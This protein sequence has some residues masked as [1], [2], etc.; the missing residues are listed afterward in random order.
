MMPL[1]LRNLA[2]RPLRSV[3]AVGGIAV[4]SAML[5]DMVML[6][7]GIERSFERMLLG[8]GYQ[9]RLSPKGTLPFD[10]EASLSGVNR[11]LERLKQDP[12]I[13]AVAPVLGGSIYAHVGDSL[14][15]LFGYGI[16]PTAQPLYEVEAGRD[17]GA[18]DT[19]GILLS[20]ASA[21][22]IS[23]LPGDTIR[24]MG[25][26]DPQVGA[27][28]VERPLVV[29]GL[30][31]WL[32]DYQD[33][34]SVGVTLS[35]MQR[36]AGPAGADRASLVIVKVRNDSVA[37][38]VAGRL[39]AELPRIEVNSVA[40]LVAH[41][42]ERLV[43]FRQLSYILGTVSLIVTVL[44]VATLLTITV[45]ERLGEIATLRAIGVSRGRIVHQMLAEGLTLTGIGAVLGVAL[46]LA[47][48]RY[49][50]AILRSF[51]G[52]PAALSF[53]VAEPHAIW[54]AVAVLALTGIVAGAYPAWIASRAPIAV[55]LRTETT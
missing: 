42:R 38:T 29:R 19:S 25:R 3:L 30:V 8:R 45:S 12:D 18:A 22:A 41:F 16:D 46:G 14:V 47:A 21:R 32:Y 35:V 51:P 50:D 34:R 6:S 48:A 9:I 1:A 37:P 15:T 49:L 36:L 26:L 5:L 24:V 31:R 10:T 28:A 53:F 39:R 4:A 54:T 44:L 2:R 55:T 33:Q 13:A 27:A 23:A 7:G 17:L 20:R 11:L 43:Y 52:L 40:Q